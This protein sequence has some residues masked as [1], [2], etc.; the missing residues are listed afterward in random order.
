[1]MFHDLT[2]LRKER[3]GDGVDVA[4]H[5]SCEQA[6]EPLP[7][8]AVPLCGYVHP[9]DASKWQMHEL[10]PG[11]GVF[12]HQENFDSVMSRKREG[13][14]DGKAMARYLMNCFWKQADL[15]GAS[16]AESPRP[17]QRSLDRGIINAILDFCSHMSDVKRPLLRNILSSKV[18]KAN[19][20]YRQ[21]MGM[22]PRKA[23]R[24]FRNDYSFY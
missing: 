21:Q 3:Q 14:L 18:T 20:L 9:Q 10:S 15:V 16:I 12:I 23:G 1:M 17:N 7:D 2:T 4:E 5:A 8:D 22:P 19:S 11:S 13:K 24:P 6:L